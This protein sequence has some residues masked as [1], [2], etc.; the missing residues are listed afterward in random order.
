MLLALNILQ[1]VLYIALLALAGQ[2]LLH[3]IAGERREGNVFYR[4]LRL[5][6]SPFTKPIRSLL[7]ASAGAGL[8]PVLA[9]CLVAL[10][11]AVVTFERIDLCVTRQ[12]LGQ[13][14]CR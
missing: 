12:L 13:P 7:P 6:G 9:F 1:L 11:Y 4:L 5:V 14:G 10:G 8:A 3:L 2:G